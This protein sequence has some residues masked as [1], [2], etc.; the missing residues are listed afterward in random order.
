MT[1][2]LSKGSILLLY[3]ENRRDY[4]SRILDRD[5]GMVCVSKDPVYLNGAAF[6]LTLFFDRNGL[7]RASLVAGHKQSDDRYRGFTTGHVHD[8]WLTD[9]FGEPD[10]KILYGFMYLRDGYE[11]YSEHDTKNGNDVILM[12]YH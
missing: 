6:T 5:G 12:R 8:Q 11:V 7:D 4:E 1:E 10:Q 2:I 9:L 3:Q